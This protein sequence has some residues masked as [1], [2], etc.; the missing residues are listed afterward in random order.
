MASEPHRAAGL[1]HEQDPVSFLEDERFHQ[2]FT[3]PPT[4]SHQRPLT[5][6]YSD[7]GY[8][9]PDEPQREHVLL[10]CGPLQGS[11]MLQLGKDK[12]A[13]RYRVRIINPDR[14]GFGG[15]SEVDAADRVRVWLEIVPAL[16]Q[17]L[18]IQHVSIACQSGG[19][20]YALNTLLYLRHLLH[21]TH[22]YIA[23]CAPWVHPSHSGASLMGL[24]NT[25]PD[26]L[27][28]S[29]GGVARFFNNKVGTVVGFSSGLLAPVAGLLKGE[30]YLA[31]GVD[32]D[33]V[34]FEEKLWPLLIKRLY[35][36]SVQGLGQ[37]A[38]LLLKRN[39]HPE[40]WGSWVDYDRFVLL[41]ADAER[42]SSIA[43]ASDALP[44][45]VEVFYAESDIMIGTGDGPEYFDNCW[46]L[47][48]R[49]DKIQYSSVVI[50][51]ANHDN[52]LDLRYGVAERIFRNMASVS[53]RGHL[54]DAGS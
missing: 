40:Y 12:L 45:K 16:L 21:P 9:N 4:P 31:P 30:P 6:T 39:E 53:H 38:L 14:P 7:Y 48:Q 54:D 26:G 8:R 25:L 43:T 10:F 47:D 24:A 18:G 32:V 52:I 22:P 41:L 23:I 27:V 13:K 35:S 46:R 42:A 29:F 28:G 49:G 3:I 51:K 36:E 20:V 19:T 5:V 33:D 44:L 37:E 2:T 17:H 50:P 15:T 11:R 1:G 34:N